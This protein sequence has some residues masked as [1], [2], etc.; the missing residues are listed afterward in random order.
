MNILQLKRIIKEIRFAISGNNHD[1]TQGSLRKA[2]F[3]LSVPMVLEMIMESIFAVVDIF[4]VAKLGSDAVAVVGLTE[5]LMTL[6]Y[7]ISIGLSTGTA[8]IISRRIGEKNKD[9]ASDAAVQAI[10]I[11]FGLSFLI[12]VP[13]VIWAK[14]IL[15]LMGANSNMIESGYMYTIIMFGGNMVIMFLFIINS[16]FRSAGDAAISL[17]VLWIANIINIILDPLLIFGIGSFDGFGIMGGAIATTTGR[18]IAVLFQFYLLFNSSNRIR[19]QFHQLKIKWNLILKLLKLSLGGIGQSLI[20]TSSWIILIRIVAVF[21]SEVLAAYTIAIRIVIFALLPS[22]GMSNAAA[23]L[24]GQNLGAKKPDR[25]EKA[26]WTTAKINMAF[27]GIIA[28]IFITFP[29]FHIRLF[30]DEALVVSKGAI[31]LRTISIG[32]L[33]YAFG[34][35]MVQAFNGAGDTTTPT[36]LNFIAFWLIEIP[37]AYFLAIILGFNENGAYIAIILSETAL[38]IIGYI[39]FR[40]GK[41]KLNNV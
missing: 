7:A 35:V 6:V 13:G 24:V 33:S 36:I 3:L 28:I 37:M 2:I 9:K 21:G 29:E 16:I 12:S 14:E 41:W 8:A 26:V 11:G 34:M 23:T 32:Y 5:S 15:E 10:A 22:W 19:I 20:A 39:F 31:A 25:A 4:F 18:G 38:S 40:K 17:R 1:F 27:L 30:I